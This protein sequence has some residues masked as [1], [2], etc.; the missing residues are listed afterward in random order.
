M[1]SASVEAQAGWHPVGLSREAQPPHPTMHLPR[2][3]QTSSHAHD[4]TVSPS[5]TASASELA[6]VSKEAAFR[7]TEVFWERR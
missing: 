7:G 4:L 3:S 6:L 5:V 1:T 2:H